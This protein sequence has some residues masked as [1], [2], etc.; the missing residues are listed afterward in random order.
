MNSSIEKFI[1]R[2]EATLK[3]IGLS[4]FMLMFVVVGVQMLGRWILNPY[5]GIGLPWTAGLSQ[6]MLVWITF[7]GAAFASRDRD[8]VSITLLYRYAPD[9]VGR[10]IGVFQTLLVVMFLIIFIY[11]ASL[12]YL[13]I[14]GQQYHVLPTFP[15]FHRG[16]LYIV[17]VAGCVFMVL[18]S[19]RDVLEIS[20]D[21]SK[22][23]F[24][25]DY[26][27]TVSE[28]ET[29]DVVDQITTED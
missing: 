14:R 11:G 24:I 10:I 25:D 20:Q 19:I 29:K 5:F 7:L 8:H 21:Y 28:E 16:W 4:V 3:F 1:D 22:Y 26:S 27:E 12:Q 18:Y 17:A 9:V 6:M 13:N 23:I 15:P 2:S